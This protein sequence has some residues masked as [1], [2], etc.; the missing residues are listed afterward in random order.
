MTS[1]ERANMKTALNT[2]GRQISATIVHGDTTW[3]SGNI[4]SIAPSIE[5]AM[6]T[7]V[8]MGIQIELD[9]VG[10]ES[11]AAALVGETLTVSL[12][13]TGDATCTKSFGDVIVKDAEYREETNSIALECYDKILWTMVPY[14]PVVDWDNTVTVYDL[15]HAI[16]THFSLPHVTTSFTNSTQIINGEKWD[17][18]YTYRDVLTEI[19]QVAGGYIGIKDGQVR[20]IYPAASNMTVTPDELRKST[21][22]D[23]FG[24]VNS[25]VIA[26]TPQEDN[27]YKRDEEASDWCEIKIEN[28]QIMDD[29]REDFLDNLYARLEGLTYQIFEID[30]FGILF[31]DFGDMFTLEALDGAAYTSLFANY[32]IRITQGI[33]ETAKAVLPSGTETDYHAADTSDRRLNQT[34]LRVDKQTHEIASLVSMTTETRQDLDGQISTLRETTQ[35]LIQQLADRINLQIS[36]TRQEISESE[37]GLQEQLNELLKFFSFTIEGLFIGAGEDETKLRLDNA[38]ISFIRAGL[39]LLSIDEHGVNA[40]GVNLSR[41]LR[42]GNFEWQNEEDGRLTLR[43]VV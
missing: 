43:K 14:E 33:S 18:S 4:V 13:V 31:L 21:I 24:P 38:I 40:E 25:L 28:N 16:C 17:E 36:Q 41:F 32:N 9:D 30:T 42:I 15:F 20:V 11:V 26:R 1:T 10:D 7:C 23:T 19:A 34:I 27:I 37:E 22:G 3:Q 29:H 2:Y 39:N 8:M 35:T 5:A 6:L 12:T